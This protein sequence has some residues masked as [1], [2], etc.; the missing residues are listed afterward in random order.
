MD[1]DL[2]LLSLITLNNVFYVFSREVF[3]IFHQVQDAFD[4][5]KQNVTFP[6]TP[7]SF[8]AS[9]QI[10]FKNPSYPWV[11]GHILVMFWWISKSFLCK[12]H[13]YKYSFISFCI[14]FISFIFYF[15]YGSG[16]NSLYIFEQ[17]CIHIL[18]RSEKNVY[19]AAVRCFINVNQVKFDIFETF[20]KMINFCLIQ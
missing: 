8:T 12:K 20:C 16:Q 18:N 6:P 9:I 15:E 19:S 5:I 2:Y 14:G 13:V 7:T 4:V 10:N 3:H 11:N 17:K 1:I